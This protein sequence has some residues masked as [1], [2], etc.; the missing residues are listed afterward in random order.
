MLNEHITPICLNTCAK[1]QPTQEHTLCDLAKC[2]PEAN[3]PT[4]LGIYVIDGCAWKMYTH[5]CL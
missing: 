2:V 3:M 5:I 4:K 1:T